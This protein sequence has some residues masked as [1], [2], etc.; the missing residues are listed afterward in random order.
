MVTTGG[1]RLS[2]LVVAHN[3]E[4]QLAD[5]LGRL[6]FAD[7][8]VVVLDR[9]TDGSRA[10]A[11]RFGARLV[12]GAWE[13]EGPRR[14]AGIDACSGDWVLEV[15][16]DERVPEALAAEI[17]D[18][19]AQADG[20]YFL[21]PFHNYVG[22]RLVRH[23]W[24]ASWGVAAKPGLFARDCKRWGDQ[25]LH[26]SLQLNGPRHWLTV[27]M[28]HLIDRNISDMLQRL[29]RYTSARA[30]DLRDSGNIGSMADNIRRMFSRFFKCY[31]SRK[32]YREG[33]YGFLIALMAALYPILSYLKARLESDG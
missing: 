6:G 27:P 19:I 22:D 1:K 7:E 10:I 5:C 30:A 17:R 20:G 11:E 4:A 23:G 26:P 32:G 13:L 9:C 33:G 28:V 14:N 16:A 25:R 2:V 24:G 15:D 8:L 21:V 18:A 29:D 31:V 12:E 3:E